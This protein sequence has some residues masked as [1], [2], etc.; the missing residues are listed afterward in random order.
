MGKTKYYIAMDEGNGIQYY[1][2]D[3]VS[4]K[5]YDFVE[6]LDKKEE[7]IEYYRKLPNKSCSIYFVRT[8]DGK[9]IWHFL[10][11]GGCENGY[12]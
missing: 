5:K 11:K 10:V 4:I 12:F 3:G 7:V 1:R 8:T 9:I 6:A 2:E